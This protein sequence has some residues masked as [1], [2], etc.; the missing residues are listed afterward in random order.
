MIHDSSILITGG[1]GSFGKAFVRMTLENY[2]PKRI[3]VLSRDEMKQWDMKLHYQNDSRI[4]FVIGDIRDKDRLQRAL[5][6]VDYVVHAAATKIVPTAEYNP[7]ECV[8]TNVIGAMNLIDACIDQGVKDVVALSTDKASNPINLY[9]ATKLAS[10]KLFI[11][12]NGTASTRGTRFSVVRYG[13]V[14]GSRGSVIPFFLSLAHTRTLPITDIRMTRFMITLTQAVKLVW[15]A[16][17][18][19][20][21]GEI[22]VRKIPSMN[23]L[24]IARASAPSANHVIVGVRPGEKIHEQMIGPEDAPFTYE[25]EDYY[26]IL[27]A[28]Y[29][30]HTDPERIKNGVSVKQD[31]IYSSDRNRD[32]MSVVDLESWINLNR[33]QLGM[34]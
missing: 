20:E 8:K 10:D 29:E 6:G 2:R 32:W 7:F 18:D 26:K 21:G 13:N 30:W 9:G 14:M 23:I 33:D 16:L 34:I 17:L 12:A 25:Y 11:A 19:M 1:T 15:S 28:I 27:P 22:Y 4:Q 31:F 24:D 3:I 5:A